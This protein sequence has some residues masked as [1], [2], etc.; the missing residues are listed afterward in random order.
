MRRTLSR[1]EK[2]NENCTHLLSHGKRCGLLIGNEGNGVIQNYLAI[3]A[4]NPVI[5]GLWL[6]LQRKAL[7]GTHPGSSFRQDVF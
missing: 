2:A 4:N 6:W 1:P 5:H 7:P 3:S